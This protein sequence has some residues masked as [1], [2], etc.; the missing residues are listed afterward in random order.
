MFEIYQFSEKEIIFFGLVLI[1]ISACIVSMPIFGSRDIPAPVKVL[2]CLLMTF[3]IFAS[4]RV[5]LIQTPLQTDDLIALG[6]REGFIGVLI[7]FLCRGIFWGVQ[8]AG[9]IL[10][11]SMGLSAA[12]IFNPAMGESGTMIEEFQTILAM[13]LFLAI[14]GH[15]WILEALSQSIRLAP[16]GVLGMKTQPLLG[17]GHFVQNVFEIGI[18]I[19]GPMMAVIIF[20]NIAMGVIGRAVPQI[21]VFIISFPVNILVGLFVFMVTIPLILSVL[22]NDFSKLT[23]DIFKFIKAF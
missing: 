1:R 10:G 4:H 8:I 18:K 14:N 23:L 17:I 20:L 22:E 21:N 19:S 9:Q 11:F 3:L 2:L 7:G 16:I 15:H 12:Q 6:A 5:Q 13:L